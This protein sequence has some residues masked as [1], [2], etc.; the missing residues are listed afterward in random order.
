MQTRSA[1]WDEIY[2]NNG[3]LE[4][5]VIIDNTE[6]TDASVPVITRALMPD[7][8]SIGNVVSA[9]CMFS[10]DASNAVGKSAEVVIKMR[11]TD[12]DEESP[13]TSE[14]L[15]NGT[16]YVSKR[17]KD[18][19]T[20]VVTYECYDA[21]LKTNSEWETAFTTWPQSMTAVAGEIATI[22][23]V[24]IDP[25][26]V[27][28][29]G[30]NYVITEPAE[31][32]IMRDVLATIAAYNGGNWVMTH[33][34]K[35]RLV[36]INSADGAGDAVTDVIDVQYTINNVLADSAREITGIRCLNDDETSY[37]VG[38]ETGIVINTTIPA[39]I[40]LDLAETLL[41]NTYQP[42][43]LDGCHYNPAV[44]L[45]DYVLYYDDVAS[46]VCSEY[47]KLGVSPN[48]VLSAPD[49]QEVEDEYPY[50]GKSDKTLAVAKAYV[51]EVV[52]DFDNDL[53]QQEI[54][55]RLTGNGIAQGMI[56]TAD[57]QLYV[58]ASY[59]QTGT[60]NAKLVNII[61]LNADNINTG[62][63]SADLI[64]IMSYDPEIQVAS[65]F[66]PDTLFAFETISGGWI[67]NG[68][69]ACAGLFRLTNAE[70]FRGKSGTLTARLSAIPGGCEDWYDAYEGGEIVDV[71]E[72]YEAFG[73]DKTYSSPEDAEEHG[74]PDASGD[75]IGVVRD[76]D[77]YI[78]THD[79]TVPN[80]AVSFFEFSLRFSKV[81]SIVVKFD[82]RSGFRYSDYLTINKTGLKVGDLVVDA[83]G[84]I[85]AG[86]NLNVA[87]ETQLG[88][89]LGVD[90]GGTGADNAE[91]ARA[92]LGVT[93]EN[94][95]AA[96][97]ITIPSTAAWADMYALF[98]TIPGGTTATFFC[99][100]GTA[101]TLLSGSNFSNTTIKGTI[102]RVN[103]T[104]YDVIAHVGEGTALSIW[105]INGL[106]S[107]SATPTIT[108]FKS[109]VNKAGDTMTGSLIVGQAND[110]AERQ[111]MTRAASGRIYM[112]STGDST[113]VRGMY[114]YNN[115]GTGGVIFNV[116]QSN[117]I[118][119]IAP[120]ATQ[121]QYIMN[122][123]DYS[124]APSENEAA[125]IAQV[126]DKNN[127]VRHN[128]YA[129][130]STTNAYYTLIVARY[131][132]SGT[133][134]TVCQFGVGITNTGAATYSVSHPA[135]LR[136]AISAAADAAAFYSATG[137]L[138]KSY[139]G[140]GTVKGYGRAVINVRGKAVE[141]NFEAQ[142]TTAG[143]VAS[144]YDIGLSVATLRSLNSSIPAFTVSNGGLLHYYT[145]AGAIDT[146][147][148]GYAGIGDVQTTNNQWRMARLYNES[149]SVGVW[150]DN[151]FTVG[152]RIVGTV[153]GTLN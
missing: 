133:S 42:F 6:Y 13:T 28:K 81:R 144:L 74:T 123:D 66:N 38:D 141:V 23:G 43:T 54:F 82:D 103:S 26:T 100:G 50:V 104:T 111:V 97:Q 51:N 145:S 35:L 60:L 101:S 45:G 27:L 59:M 9:V 140:T 142:I 48:G 91:D 12:N 99:N 96:T 69:Q 40:A 138:I 11:M 34:N 143:T 147:R 24:T 75:I 146:N 5:S 152:M 117:R 46:I 25:R 137:I 22:I 87:G 36:P 44:E 134:N 8:I 77:E 125:N 109:F 78:Y 15:A 58:N 136:S 65:E 3:V 16:Y 108:G 130:R 121:I 62:T 85:E 95:N 2:A 17:V 129:L 102:T 98:D 73:P 122:P 18:P 127:Y 126:L 151:A 86:G 31:G 80:E 148:E 33:E 115:A 150:G 61:N 92:N 29:T 131:P 52:N 79:F 70:K 19:I 124:S 116:D 37:L 149:G 139:G 53:T 7:N 1:A 72:T 76:G 119:A 47:V 153:Y 30:V 132:V 41:G 56:L 113:G 84:N 93:P 110:T 14:W 49:V 21:L 64:E 112:R 94:I 39:M 90:Y 67:V 135:A 105:R 55:D 20:N 120:F 10:M 106:S 71:V 88:E 63:L 57:G 118:S 89:P 68:I 83:E 4:T 114:G 32:T 107:A 128:I